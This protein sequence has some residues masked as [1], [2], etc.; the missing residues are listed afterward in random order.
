[1]EFKPMF[2]SCLIALCMAAIQSILSKGKRKN[3]PFY[4]LSHIGF[5]CL[6]LA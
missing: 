5:D 6:H 4:K 1:M 3:V 2:K